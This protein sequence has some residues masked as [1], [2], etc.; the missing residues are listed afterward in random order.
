MEKRDNESL[1][2]SKHNSKVV[3]KNVVHYFS[4]VLTSPG[5]TSEDDDALLFDLAD[6]RVDGGI[7]KGCDPVK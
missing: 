1:M 3:L 6:L 2:R 7:C 4:A 5:S